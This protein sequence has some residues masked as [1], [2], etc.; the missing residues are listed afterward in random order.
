M[1]DYRKTFRAAAVQAEPVWNDLDGGI[2]KL[3]ALAREARAGG[4]D[5][6][7]FPEVWIPGYP[8]FLWLDSVAWQSQF[9][10]P[11]AANSIE[12]GSPEWERLESIAR[13]V[14]IALAFGFSERAGGS[15]YMGQAFIDA[16]GRTL[17]TRRKLKPTHVERTQFGDGDG[18]DVVV[19][20][21]PVGRV[22][23][24]NCW[25][26]LQPLTKYAMF[27]Q[28]E[29]LHV[30]AWPSFSIFPGV[31]NALGP[32]VNIGASRQYAVEG[33]T[34]VLAPCAVVGQAAH[35][36]FAD[37]ELKKQFLAL[38][39]GYARIFGPDGSS[40]AEPLAPTEEGILYADIDFAAILA[41]KNA[42]DPVGH[43]SRPDVFTLHHRDT[44]RLPKVSASGRDIPPAAT[45]EVDDLVGAE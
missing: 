25:E 40:L 24:L 29:Q 43:Y 6:V 16:E 14:G 42:A 41:A 33:Q 17:G 39:G 9:V 32:E 36:L 21:T 12:I 19:I 45:A 27:S 37:T 10:V 4:A 5:I 38:G 11:Y 8:W 1:P 26:H 2:G 44:G 13:S 20:D 34:F 30:G 23:S 18:S 15:L 35:D 31:V 22:G 28:D 3:E 7:A